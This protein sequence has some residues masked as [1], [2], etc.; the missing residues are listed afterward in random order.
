MSVQIEPAP[1]FPLLHRVILG[2]SPQSHYYGSVELA[3]DSDAIVDC[4]TSAVTAGEL[5]RKLGIYLA[6]PDHSFS[7][8]RKMVSRPGLLGSIL[9]TEQPAV[10]ARQVAVALDEA[11]LLWPRLNPSLRYYL[12]QAAWHLRRPA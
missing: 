8:I 5:V 6:H 1:R 12:S 4:V 11:L 10:P 7:E 3:G 2:W 9:S